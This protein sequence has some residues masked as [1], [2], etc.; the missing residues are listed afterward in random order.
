MK[1]NK[2]LI[3]VLAAILPAVSFAD[4]C[5]TS[6]MPTFT[7]A[8]ASAI[9]TKAAGSAV[10]H[11]IIPA[12]T[13]TYALGSS[14][15]LWSNVFTSTLT[16]P[17]A[18]TGIIVG[19]ASRAANVT[20]ATGSAPTTYLSVDGSVLSGGALVGTGANANAFEFDFF[21]TRATS[22]QATT[23]V[24]SG[25]S[26]GTLRFYGANGTGYSTAGQIVATV[27][28][29]PGASADM[30]GAIDFQLSPDGSATM[31]SVLKLKNDKS[32][33]FTGAIKSTATNLGWQSRAGANTACNTTC[34]AAHGCVFG[35][36]IGT[37]A[38]VDCTSALADSCI[39]SF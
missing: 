19:E 32:A 13:N 7:S 21:K 34:T 30:P 5:S 38:V 16:L 28:A 14:S 18:A 1:T 4:T 22:G 33:N 37:T 29:T 15:K 39:C 6:L 17:T 20:T 10:N 3:A 23:I 27:D 35:Y 24:Q 9:C 25:D 26:L 11:S 36:D 2:I 8:Q 31:A 12:T